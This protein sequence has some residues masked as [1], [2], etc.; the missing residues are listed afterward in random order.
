MQFTE[1]QQLFTLIFAI[2]FTLIIDRVHRNYNPYD[3]YNAWKG[4]K[5]AINRL[6]VSWS[7]MY[8]L[9]LLNF[10]IFFILLGIYD[11]RFQLD[12]YGILNIVLVGLLS[13]FDFG[14]YRIFESILYLSPN[15]FY[16]SREANEILDDERNEF[17]AHF[18]PGILYVIASAIMILIVIIIK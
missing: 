5:H 15:T 10:G 3:T 7:V 18:I 9:P 11:I 1:A 16:T 8:I 14:Y 17:Q 2:H 4:R 6:L 13:F 12:L